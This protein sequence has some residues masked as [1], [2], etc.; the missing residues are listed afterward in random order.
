MKEYMLTTIDNP[1]DPFI[2]WDEWLAF[3]I[4]KGYNTCEYVAKIARTYPEMS[5]EAEKKEIN[6]AI[7]EIVKMNITG[8]Y[9]MVEKK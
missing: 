9:I 8:N 1:F 5:E 2:Q 4:G 6:N 3:D 7:E